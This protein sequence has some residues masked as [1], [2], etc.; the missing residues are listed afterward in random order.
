MYIIDETRSSVNKLD[1]PN[2][3]GGLLKKKLQEQE[4]LEKEK[5]E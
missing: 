4:Q 3:Y 1:T 5:R 2:Y